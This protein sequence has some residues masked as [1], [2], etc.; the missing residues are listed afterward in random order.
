MNIQATQDDMCVTVNRTHGPY[1]DV[2]WRLSQ[3]LIA[4]LST[5]PSK[6]YML[7]SVT[8]NFGGDAYAVQARHL[9]PL[10]RGSATIAIMYEGK[11]SVHSTIVWQNPDSKYS[12]RRTIMKR[13]TRSY[14]VSIESSLFADLHKPDQF[15]FST[16]REMIK[17]ISRI[18]HSATGTVKMPEKMSG[19]SRLINWLTVS[20]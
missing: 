19:L 14:A 3:E 11:Y 9:V 16:E 20:G 13:Y 6:L 18:G 8:K 15:I 7:I 1:V 5:V 2:G 17:S 10:D 12:L 4:E